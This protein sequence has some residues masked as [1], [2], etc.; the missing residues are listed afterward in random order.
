MAG[1]EEPVAPGGVRKSQEMDRDGGVGQTL[2]VGGK[3]ADSQ[4]AEGNARLVI[5]KMNHAGV[6]G[7]EVRIACKFAVTQCRL[8]LRGVQGKGEDKLVIEPM[9]HALILYTNTTGVLDTARVQEGGRSRLAS[10]NAI[11]FAGSK[12][13]P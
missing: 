5:L 1:K 7:D 11:K 6:G 8:E 2:W 9:F 4:V 3:N 13:W 12:P 10:E